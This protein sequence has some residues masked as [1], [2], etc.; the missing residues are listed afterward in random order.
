M[1]ATISHLPTATAIRW[2][3]GPDRAH[4]GGTSADPVSYQCCID[5]LLDLRQSTTDPVLRGLVSEV[6]AEL[7]TIGPVGDDPELNEM[8]L[9]ALGSVQSAFEL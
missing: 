6:L 7:R 8:V 2:S 3:D 1:T 9:G 5:W 4:N